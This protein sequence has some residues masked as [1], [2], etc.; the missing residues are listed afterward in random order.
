[1][2]EQQ[3]RRYLAS[4][5]SHDDREETKMM[6]HKPKENTTVQLHMDATGKQMKTKEQQFDEVN[7]YWL[8]DCSSSQAIGHT[9]QMSKG[10]LVTKY[11][12]S[13]FH[14]GKHYLSVGTSQFKGVSDDAGFYLQQQQVSGTAFLSVNTKSYNQ[15]TGF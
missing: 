5:C 1:M 7:Q 15:D 3:K 11:I 6:Q 14:A 13:N 4:R 2:A 10:Y 8:Q 12:A 9:D